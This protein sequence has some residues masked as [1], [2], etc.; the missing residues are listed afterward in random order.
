MNAKKITYAGLKKVLKPKQM[1]NI[2]GGYG[3]GDYCC[4]YNTDWTKPGMTCLVMGGP[5]EAEFMAGPNG[6]WECGTTTVK[7]NCGC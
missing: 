1:Q 5:A 7:T 4:A 3:S 2:L 6:H